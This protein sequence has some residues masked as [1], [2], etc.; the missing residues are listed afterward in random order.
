MKQVTAI[1][2]TAVALIAATSCEKVPVPLDLTRAQAEYV[3]NGNTFAGNLLQLVDAKET[4]KDYFF[5]PLSVQ[6]ALSMLLNG[7]DGEAYNELCQALGYGQDLDAVNDFCQQMIER[8]PTWDPKV[9]IS[10]ANAMIGNDRFTF[11]QPFIKALNSIYSAEVKNM[12]FSQTEKVLNYINNWGKAKTGGMIPT[13]LERDQVSPDYLLY[14]INA[15]CFKGEWQYK[16]DKKKTK[17]GEFHCENGNTRKVDMMNI[18]RDYPYSEGPGWRSIAIPYGKGRFSMHVI[19]PEGDSTVTD[20]V[21]TIQEK[22][23]KAFL[24][25]PSEEEVALMFPKFETDY[26]EPE[27]KD[28]IYDLGVRRIFEYSKFSRITDDTQ[29]CV[30]LITHKAKIKVTEEKTEAAAATVVGV[31]YAAADLPRI[32]FHCDRPFLYAIVEKTTGAI[33]FV[34]KYGGNQ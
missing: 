8:S 11:K 5:S 6:I 29:C 34:G 2:F 13:M 19:L 7:T 3:S 32:I 15:L 16:F 27:F 25:K 21:G 33:F 4:E 24:D 28:Y 30:T 22:G 9:D 23:W 1:L 17:E 20:L 14:L 31:Y 18:I 26:S 12:D 10:F